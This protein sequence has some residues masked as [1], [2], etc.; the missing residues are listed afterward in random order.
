MGLAL[1]RRNPLEFREA[2][3]FDQ[4]TVLREEHEDV[5]H[6][7]LHDPQVLVLLWIVGEIGANEVYCELVPCRRSIGENV[8]AHAVKQINPP[9]PKI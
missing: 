3:F 6:L 9:Y 7:P 1:D 8:H 5:I 2:P 4:H